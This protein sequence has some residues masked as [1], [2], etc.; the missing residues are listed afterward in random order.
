MGAGGGGG[1]SE[2]LPLQKKGGGMKYFSHAK[3]GGGH[4][5]F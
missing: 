1:A 5:M 3:V 2:V 4:N